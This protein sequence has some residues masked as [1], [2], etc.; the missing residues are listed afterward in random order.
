MTGADDVIA[1]TW[2]ITGFYLA[3]T[4]AAIA[5][6]AAQTTTTKHPPGLGN[7]CRTSRPASD[8]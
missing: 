8:S 1:L 4:A 7:P 5:P 2:N 3:N 6:T